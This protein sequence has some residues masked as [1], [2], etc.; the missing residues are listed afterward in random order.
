RRVQLDDLAEVR[1]MAESDDPVAALDV[2]VER[3]RD[4]PSED[5]LEPLLRLRFRAARHHRPHPREPWPPAYDDPFPELDGIPELGAGELD[6]APGFGAIAHHGSVIVRGLFDEAAVARSVAS[7]ERARHA[8]LQGP[9]S[10]AAPAYRP[11]EGL[12]QENNVLRHQ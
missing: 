10:W 3:Y 2:L 7:L 1:R 6:S 12:D 8:F 5:L 9:R 4:A 11:I